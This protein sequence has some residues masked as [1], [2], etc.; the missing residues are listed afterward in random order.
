MSS[1]SRSL[2]LHH[3]TDMFW[4]HFLHPSTP[5]HPE[6]SRVFQRADGGLES[7]KPQQIQCEKS[8]HTVQLIA[9]LRRSLLA[10][11]FIWLPR[12]KN[13]TSAE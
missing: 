11:V 12:S 3:S 1:S 9:L 7:Q 10:V 6:L 2:C 8:N 5:I 4:Q 13:R